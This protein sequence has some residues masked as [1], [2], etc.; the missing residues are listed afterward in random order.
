MIY[1]PVKIDVLIFGSAATAAGT[2]RLTVTIHESS[3][4]RDVGAAL[5]EQHPTLKDF[6][7]I[8]RLAVNH[9]FVKPDCAIRPGDEIALITLV[10]GG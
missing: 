6:F 10:S 7:G 2:D 9:A 3:T 1:F 5:I 4:V 8:P